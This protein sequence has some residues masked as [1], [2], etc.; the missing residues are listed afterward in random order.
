MVLVG[1]ELLDPARTAVAPPESTT[2]EM[3]DGVTSIENTTS[4]PFAG[5][6]N[7][8]ASDDE[9]EVFGEE[10]EAVT[11]GAVAVLAVTPVWEGPMFCAYDGVNRL[12]Q[13]KNIN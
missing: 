10:Q 12:K 8:H 2:E 7:V 9:L 4:K 11:C 1:T 13:A 5:A 6:V 3:A